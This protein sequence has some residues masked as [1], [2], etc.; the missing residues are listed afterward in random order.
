MTTHNAASDRVIRPAPKPSLRVRWTNA[1]W[2]LRAA[3]ITG[4]VVAMPVI[5]FIITFAVNM[6]R[7]VVGNAQ[8]GPVTAA[9]RTVSLD[10]ITAAGMVAAD[11]LGPVPAILDSLVPQWQD[12]ENSVYPHLI[13]KATALHGGDVAIVLNPKFYEVV[14]PED[15]AARVN[16]MR[17]S[18]R[19][20][21]A[22]S[23][24]S[25]PT[26]GT[27]P[28]PRVIVYRLVSEGPPPRFAIVAFGDS[29]AHTL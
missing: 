17:E 15:Q 9:W 27:Y 8:P 14:S 19:F 21:L 1:S 12:R 24:A 16:E 10:S 20:V 29:A 18:W 2:L 11:T 13:V 7:V 4:G 25:W 5:A 3:L 6:G 28:A 23:G 22:T 26:D